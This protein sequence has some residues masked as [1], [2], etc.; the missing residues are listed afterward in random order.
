[1]QSTAGFFG[2]DN[3]TPSL[4]AKCADGTSQDVFPY[5]DRTTATVVDPFGAETFNLLDTCLAD[6]AVAPSGPT[7]PAN[8]LPQKQ[9]VSVARYLLAN[10]AYTQTSVLQPAARQVQNQLTRQWWCVLRQCG[11]HNT[12]HHHQHQGNKTDLQPT[13]AKRLHVVSPVQ[14][15]SD[16]FNLCFECMDTGLT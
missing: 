6:L 5:L 2:G 13:A 3:A 15:L 4:A 14:N 11:R 8:L 7:T 1:S 16:I 9:C 12:K 10:T